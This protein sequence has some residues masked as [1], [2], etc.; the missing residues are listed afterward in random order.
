MDELLDR[1]QTSF[2]VANQLFQV[3]LVSLQ[4]ANLTSHFT[5]L[6]PPF[7]LLFSEFTEIGF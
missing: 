7:F 5:L 1:S 6:V 4:H 2:L 3:G